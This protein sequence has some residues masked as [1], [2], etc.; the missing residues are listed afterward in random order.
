[1]DF[2][3]VAMDIERMVENHYRNLADECSADK[4]IK[5]IMTMLAD[6]H[7]KHRISFEQMKNEQNV[8]PLPETP[9]FT[10]AKKVFSEMKD[11]QKPYSCDVDQVKHYEKALELVQHKGKIYTKALENIEDEDQQKAINRIISEEK[12][13]EK[14]LY[15]IIEMVNRPK[16]WLEDAEVYHLDEY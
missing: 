11:Q 5:N 2:F 10:E 12:H 7:K 8:L 9:A 13:Q 15:N 4:G 1:M 14:V 3:K 16:T 6:D